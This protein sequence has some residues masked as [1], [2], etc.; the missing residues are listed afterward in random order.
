[1]LGRVFQSSKIFSNIGE[2]GGTGQWLA[3]CE[4]FCG[5]E[6]QEVECGV[7]RIDR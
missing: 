2:G 7:E 1:M 4:V 3:G 6:E 5:C